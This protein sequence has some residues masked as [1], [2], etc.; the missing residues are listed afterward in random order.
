MCGGPWSGSLMR[1]PTGCWGS[2]E[3]GGPVPGQVL[4]GRWKPLHYLLKASAFADVTGSCCARCVSSANC[5]VKN[6]GA[7]D[8][9]GAVRVEFVD[10]ATGATVVAVDQTLSLAA[11][12]QTMAWLGAGAFPPAAT[13][14]LVL[15]ILNSDNSTVHSRNEILL[16]PPKNLTLPAVTVTAAVSSAANSDGSVDVAVTATGGVAA[17]VVCP[18]RPRRLSTLSV[19]LCKSVLYGA[20]VWARGALNS[21]KRRFPARVGRSAWASRTLARSCTRRRPRGG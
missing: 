1:S 8:F 20:F 11:G 6:D 18:G 16:A 15:T 19:F 17:Y 10:F 2:V 13:H 21:R 4:G 14:A 12:A 7:F 5:Y 9:S 3:Y